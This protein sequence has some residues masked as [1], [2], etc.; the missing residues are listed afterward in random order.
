MFS[1][2]ENTNNGEVVHFGMNAPG[3]EQNAQF[4]LN[5]MHWLAG[6]LTSTVQ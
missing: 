1:A 6:L 5:V 2:Q 3:A 4:I